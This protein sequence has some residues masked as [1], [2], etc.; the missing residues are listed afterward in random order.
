MFVTPLV[1]RCPGVLGD[2]MRC[3]TLRVLSWN[4]L[5]GCHEAEA[6]QGNVTECY[7]P[8]VVET[9]F[10]VRAFA[11]CY[12]QWYLLYTGVQGDTMVGRHN[13]ENW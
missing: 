8:Q 9:L 2:S 1:L 5:W 4:S 13:N 3:S 12:H 11:Q 7:C 6:N 10:S